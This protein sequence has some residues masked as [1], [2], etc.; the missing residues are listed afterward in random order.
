MNSA[1]RRDDLQFWNTSHLLMC[2]SRWLETWKVGQTF[3]FTA[4]TYQAKKKPC[5]PR[6][7]PCRKIRKVSLF[8]ETKPF[9]ETTGSK[10]AWPPE[11]KL[12]FLVKRQTEANTPKLRIP[13]GFLWCIWWKMINVEILEAK[14]IT[15]YSSLRIANKK[16]LAHA[17]TLYL[18]YIKI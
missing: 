12:I 11:E 1:S 7:Y 2:Q 6:A 9:S 14:N 18:K 8:T 16:P 13:A 10:G 17:N 4:L 3:S 15:D 5:E